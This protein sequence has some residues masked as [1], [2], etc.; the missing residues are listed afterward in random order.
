MAS[1]AGA[2]AGKV[3]QPSFEVEWPALAQRLAISMSDKGFSPADREDLIQETGLRLYSV[4]HRLR[5]GSSPWPLAVTIA[6]NLAR[7]RSRRARRELLG[8]VP[9]IA[10]TDDVEKAG[11]ARVE[12][13]SV[14]RC[15]RSLKPTY[16][17]ALLAQLG[18][19]DA[20]SGSTS[21]QKMARLRARRALEQMVDRASVGCGAA[22][23][24]LRRAFEVASEIVAFRSTGVMDFAIAAATAGLIGAGTLLPSAAQERAREPAVA[25]GVTSVAADVGQQQE[26]LDGLQRKVVVGHAEAQASSGSD[27]TR[28]RRPS[29]RWSSD[30]TSNDPLVNLPVDPPSQE[31]PVTAPLSEAEVKTT[32]PEAPSL[33]ASG[34]GGEDNAPVDV[35]ATVET[36]TSVLDAS[37]SA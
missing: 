22:L 1:A 20:G 26:Q 30:G 27:G 17:S 32:P 28:S 15:I 37:I 33:P 14:A 10:S 18:V 21:A 2:R 3:F 23:L 25:G 7:D 8:S 9:D 31:A 36:V 34:G 19:A 35:E 11:I 13:A 12:L 29:P 5:P 24:K 6:L 4:W 16:R